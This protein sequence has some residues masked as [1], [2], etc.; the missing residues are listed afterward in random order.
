MEKQ[1]NDY[2]DLKL[3]DINL[4]TYPF[5]HAV[6]DN[7]LPL[8]QFKLITNSIASIQNRN[9]QKSFSTELESN[10]KLHFHY[11]SDKQLML[12]INILSSDK[13]INLIGNLFKVN[14]LTSLKE[15]DSYGGYSPFHE[16]NDNGYLGSH[17]DHSH[18]NEKIHIANAIYY[19]SNNWKNEW[20]GETLLF[21]KSGLKIRKKIICKPNRLVLFVNSSYSFHGVNT[22]NSNGNSRFSYYMDYNCNK[23]D[24]EKMYQYWSRKNNNPINLT[25]WHHGTTFLP[26]YPLETI[27]FPK[28]NYKNLKTTFLYI[29]TYIFNYMLGKLSKNIK[30]LCLE[31]KK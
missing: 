20:G 26:F 19:C 3:E 14:N 1:F 21:N 9:I 13:A 29:H 12:P 30:K 2:F 28:F 5:P 7:F 27:K 25:S 8:D 16:M 6:I 15:F 10:K 18:K 22:I 11:E 24:A 23:Y 31:K 17:V 4:H